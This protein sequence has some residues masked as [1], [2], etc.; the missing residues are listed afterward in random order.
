MTEVRIFGAR[1]ITNHKPTPYAT[2]AD[3]CRIFERDINR[4]YML[5]F[6]LTADH[7]MAENCFVRGL[8]TSVTSSSVFKEWAQSWATRTIIQNAIQMIRPP[9]TDGGTSSSM[10]NCSM[11]YAMTKPAKIAAIVELP[12]FERFIFVMSVLE[13]YSSQDRSLLLDCTSRDVIAAQARALQQIGKSAE[14]DHKPV[15]IGSDGQLL[16]DHHESAL[17]AESIPRLVASP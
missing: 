8:D 9:S 10:L 6:L 2:S 4:L 14:L 16:R 5:S 13:C 7:S 12:A 1:K 11:A 3:F 17:P 15:G